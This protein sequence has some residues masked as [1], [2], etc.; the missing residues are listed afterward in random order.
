MYFSTI[1]NNKISK[2][3]TVF[4]LTVILLVVVLSGVKK[5]SS[6]AKAEATILITEQVMDALEYFYQ[7]QERYPTVF[8]YGDFE[9]ISWYFTKYPIANFSSENCPETLKYIRSSSQKYEL[10]FCLTSP[11]GKYAQGWNKINVLK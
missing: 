5:G 8:E 1:V 3:L 11:V 10:D 4:I 6:T 2:I 9:T 7:D